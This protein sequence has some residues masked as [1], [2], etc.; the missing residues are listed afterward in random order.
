MKGKNK[1]TN[2]VNKNGTLILYYIP[3]DKDD[4]EVPNGFL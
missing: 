4:L 3:E 2:P 1:S